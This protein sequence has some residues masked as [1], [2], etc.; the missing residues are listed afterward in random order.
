MLQNTKI[1]WAQDVN[2]TYRK[3]SEDVLDILWTSYVPTIYILFSG[4]IY[5]QSKIGRYYRS[6]LI[7]DPSWF[8]SATLG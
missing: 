7:F 3:R 1:L 2:W 8:T 5:D 6:L 4:R